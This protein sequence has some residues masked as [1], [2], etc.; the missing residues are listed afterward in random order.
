MSRFDD[1]GSGPRGGGGFSRG[2]GR[3][4]GAP[5][6]QVYVGDLNPETQEEDLQAPFGKY[7]SIRHIWVAKNPPGFGFVDFE[8]PRDAQDCVEAMDGSVFNGRYA[9]SSFYVEFKSSDS[10]VKFFGQRPRRGR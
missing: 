4:G 2:G 1:G 10:R 6:A 3:G 9:R 7:G 5:N 8:D